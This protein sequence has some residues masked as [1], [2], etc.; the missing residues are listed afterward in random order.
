M[1]FIVSKK[2]GHNGML[3]VVT[4]KEIVGKIFTEGKRQLDLTKDFYRGKDASKED[5][6][7]LFSE[8]RDLHLTGKHSVALGIEL[9][10]VDAQ[11]ILY[12]KSVPHAQ[13]AV[14]G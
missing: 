12:V 7:K 11:H 8:A 6:A 10:Y 14:M 9:G 3:L 5:V 1:V 2:E 13:V 4:D